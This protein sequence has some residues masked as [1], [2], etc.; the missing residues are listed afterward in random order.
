MGR[1][2]YFGDVIVECVLIYVFIILLMFYIWYRNKSDQ[3]RPQL[4]TYVFQNIYLPSV[5]NES[6][7]NYLAYVL[8]VFR[9]LSLCFFLGWAVIGNFVIRH[10]KSDLFL[11]YFTNWN[12]LFISSYYI[13]ATTCSII[14]LTSVSTDW[15]KY[16]EYLGYFTNVVFE[17]TGGTA[18]FVTIVTFIYLERVF[19]L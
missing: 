2:T 15:S 5:K 6:G 17:V 8:L 16:V 7:Q 9:I 18:F 1:Y 19:T 13:L 11:E 3:R 14:G 4:C 12:I 10:E